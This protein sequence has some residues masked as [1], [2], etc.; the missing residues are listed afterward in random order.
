MLKRMLR[1][2]LQ[3]RNTTSWRPRAAVAGPHPHPLAALASPGQRMPLETEQQLKSSLPRHERAILARIAER[4]ESGDLDL[5]R[6]SATAMTVMELAATPGVSTRELAKALAA[7]S[8]L[9]VELLRTANTAPAGTRP[10]ETL[11]E[12]IERVGKR[13]LRALV[14]R[15]SLRATLLRQR[16]AL[17]LATEVWRQAQSVSRLARPVARAAGMDPEQGALLGL[18]HDIGKVSLIAM[19]VREAPREAQLSS[20]LFGQVFARFHERA[21]VAL[22]RAWGLPS[23]LVS[24]A[25]CH[26][27]FELNEKHLKSAA[28]VSLAHKMD[29]CI[30]QRDED[31]FRA[32]A[33]GKE[34]DVLQVPAV[35]RRQ[36]LSD[37]YIDSASR[38][39]RVA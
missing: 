26:E 38:V 8:A 30:A 3:R 19:L 5:P 4:V 10:L 27:R 23:E 14:V 28:L 11:P 1:R 33:D 34:L 36:M 17:P 32:L 9:R 20:A 2:L 22:A 16:G 39:R 12:A 31:A 25:G 18:V 29:L 15:A 21:G 7:D 13:R 37:I 24:V 6:M 35:V